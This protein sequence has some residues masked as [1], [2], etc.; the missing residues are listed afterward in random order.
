[1]P[2]HKV[3]L[4]EDDARVREPIR[5]CLEH[6]G[7]T[8]WE[9]TAGAGGLALAECQQPD[10]ILLDL[11]LPDTDGLEVAQELRRRPTT[12][13]IPIVIL[14]GQVLAGRRAEVAASICAGIIPKPVGL[15][16]LGRDLRLLLKVRR[17][18]T[19]RFTR[20]RVAA[21]VGWRLRGS[22]DA[23]EADYVGGVARSLS[24]GGVMVE[25]P[26][27]LPTASLVDLRL[28]TPAGPF[29]T[30]GKVV[31]ARFRDEGLTGEGAY[32]HGIQFLDLESDGHEAI[33][34]LTDLAHLD[35]S[36]WYKIALMT[37]G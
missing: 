30:V 11:G 18:S 28:P 5:L 13:R 2:R 32:Q 37:L 10:L 20:A 35:K 3:L 31:W 34:Q 16:R 26:I 23:C 6:L 8:V 36:L 7:Y 25:L 1:M 15:E 33:R 12:A 19:R 29:T 17:R 21:P 14:T 27:P 4:V 24:E 22:G 9:A